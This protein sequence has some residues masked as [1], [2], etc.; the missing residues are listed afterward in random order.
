MDPDVVFVAALSTQMVQI[1]EQADALGVSSRLIVPDLTKVEVDELGAAAGN[2]VAFAGWSE[3]DDSPKNQAFVQSYMDKHGSIPSPWAAQAYASLNILANA[4][5]EAGSTEA[6]A[7]RD[8]LAQ[9]SQFDT[10]LGSFS[11][12]PNGEAIYEQIAVLTVGEDGTLQPL[13][14]Q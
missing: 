3:L 13:S 4:I 10:V 11:F 6:A 5:G 1:I 2:A 14:S 7:I 12:D 8:A 9:T